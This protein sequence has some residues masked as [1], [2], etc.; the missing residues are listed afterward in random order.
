MTL[1][2]DYSRKIAVYF[3]KNKDEV[4]QSIK[5]FV[6]KVER[7]KDLKIKRFRTDDGLEYCNKELQE[8][9]NKLGIRHERS[10]VE[11]PQMNGVAECVNRTLMDLVRSMLTSAKLPSF[12]AEATSAVTYVRNRMIHANLEDGVPEGIWN[13]RIPSV[14]HLKAYRCLAYAHLPHQGRRKLDPRV[15]TCVL[16]GYSSQTKGYRL[17]DVKRKEI[18]QTK[19]V[20]FVETKLGYEEAEET[21]SQTL[22]GFPYTDF[23]Q[24]DKGS[25]NIQ[26]DT[27]RN[28]HNR[29]KKQWVRSEPIQTRSRTNA[30]SKQ[31]EDD[32]DSSSEHDEQD[33]TQEIVGASS[34]EKEESNRFKKKIRNRMVVKV[35]Q[36]I[37]SN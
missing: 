11:T 6:N 10:C 36:R 17:W 26:V 2:D 35:N 1:T 32:E 20:R 21:T 14:K 23:S 3:L 7:D 30:Q 25:D 31:D 34:N 8:F 16:V 24:E 5:N 27:Q 22:F 12:W 4:V 28:K 29:D 19:H 9:F 15:R 37:I 33:K 18:I 13:G